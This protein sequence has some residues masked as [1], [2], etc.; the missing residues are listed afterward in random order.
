MYGNGNA[1]G[2]YGSGKK[3]YLHQAI[4]QGSYKI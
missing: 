3:Q 2:E 4:D 1:A